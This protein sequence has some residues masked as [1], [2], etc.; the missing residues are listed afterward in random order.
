MKE[1]T[2]VNGPCSVL[3]VRNMDIKHINVKSESCLT[4][5]MN[6]QDME[7]KK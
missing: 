4:E 7:N 3:T 1:G 6:S 2:M 5:E